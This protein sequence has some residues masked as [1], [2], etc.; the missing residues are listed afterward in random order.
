MEQASYIEKVNRYHKKLN[1]D[2]TGE[3]TT[4]LTTFG[5]V[6]GKKSFTETE[7]YSQRNHPS[8]C[9]SIVQGSASFISRA[10]HTPDPKFT[11]PL[12]DTVD[13][14][15]MRTILKEQVI[16]IPVYTERVVFDAAHL[17]HLYG[18]VALLAMEN[19]RLRWK[20]VQLQQD[21]TLEMS[22]RQ[23]IS[24][25]HETSLCEPHQGSRQMYEDLENKFNSL[26]EKYGE[27]RE[28]N[29]RKSLEIEKLSTEIKSQ[30]LEIDHLR[31]ENEAAATALYVDKNNIFAKYKETEEANVKLEAK[32]LRIEHE[33]EAHLCTKNELEKLKGLFEEKNEHLEVTKS[34][35][36]ISVEDSKILRGLVASREKEIEKLNL[37]N[38]EL[39]KIAQEYTHVKQMLDIARRDIETYKEAYENREKLLL[40]LGREL[41]E[42][43]NLNLLLQEKTARISFLEDE[44]K[45][46]NDKIEEKEIQLE[47]MRSRTIDQDLE[48]FRNN[49]L[50]S[51]VNQ[52][53]AKLDFSEKKLA[54]RGEENEA[55]QRKLLEATLRIQELK[56]Y[57]IKLDQ[58]ATERDE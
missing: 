14:T 18:Q 33:L 42:I 40:K 58:I 2:T 32:L 54:L 44:I 21:G 36:L 25:I 15:N 35:L 50:S 16:E 41:S 10:D 28:E 53:T 27:A 17:A 47:I 56:T 38:A 45:R 3:R 26:L 1:L 46:L 43:D 52:L 23:K 48:K 31:R 9:E 13:L 6:S 5:D 55:L 49:E 8:L 22:D 20:V 57:E 34:Q 29:E 51:Q 37:K 12:R 30:T 7:V 19:R 24:D 4:N 39:I 11:N